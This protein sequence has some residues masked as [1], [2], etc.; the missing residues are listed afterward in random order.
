MKTSFPKSKI[1]VVLAEGVHPSGE[2]ILRDE[3]FKVDRIDGA[4]APADLPSALAGAHIV[5]I[6]SKT[7]IDA[8]AIDGT[9]RLLAIGCFCIGTNQVDTDAS[10]LRGVPVFNSP[11][12]NTRSVAELTICEIIALHRRLAD[13]SAQMHAG[14]WQ[15]SSSGAHEIRGRTLGIVGYGRIGSQVSV[16]AEAMGM[17]VIFYDQVQVLPLGNARQAKSL[18]ELLKESDV[19]TLHVPATPDTDTL[20]GAKELGAMKPGAMLINNAR[21]TV[22]DVDALAAALKSG[23]IGGAAV[24]VF[25]SEPGA[26]GPGFESALAGAPNVVLTPHVG[27][28]TEE[29]QE[30]IAKD[31]A[32]KLVR[33]VNNGS[34]TGGVNVPEVELPEQ[35]GASGERVHRILHFHRNVPGV[36]TKLHAVISRTNANVV[37]EHLRTDE[38]VGYVV[39]DVAP[40]DDWGATMLDELKAIPETLGV[41]LLW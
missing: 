2:A 20:I 19:V 18:K 16:L 29:A 8:T 28:S 41:R 26:N 7:Q 34:T 17:R 25:P 4:I 37:A 5:G 6:R 30:S 12:S 32:Q 40:M 15:K 39:L 11:F 14:V 33:F 31:V 23:S 3:G 13:R 35:V 38:R 9:D 36:L 24:D 27:G 22:V 21:G 1:R 10:A